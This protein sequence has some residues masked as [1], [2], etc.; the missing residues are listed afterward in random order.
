MPVA[1]AFFTR[2]GDRW[3]ADLIGGP[4]AL[5]EHGAAMWEFVG[6]SPPPRRR[7]DDRRRTT[8]TAWQPRGSAGFAPAE[9][10]LRI[11]LDG[12][13]R[14]P[15]GAGPCPRDTPSRPTPAGRTGW[16]PATASTWP[17]AWR[18]RACTDATWTWRSWRGTRWPATACS[19]PTPSPASGSSSRCAS[20]TSTPR[21][22]LGGALLTEGLERLAAAGCTRFKVS[23]D[24]SNT[25]A[26]RLYL[27]AGFRPVSSARL[28]RRTPRA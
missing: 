18:R 17:S 22:G 21:R 24:P 4:E 15:A 20:R 19:G 1:A 9:L 23:F 2:W 16:P 13:R 28:L 5:A 26:A 25:A 7:G 14:S 3:G 12:R 10:P 11:G 27:G 6:E 8:T